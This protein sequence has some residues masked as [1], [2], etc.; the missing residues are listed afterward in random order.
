[1]VPQTGGIM[2]VQGIQ[3]NLARGTEQAE[4]SGLFASCQIADDTRYLRV[5]AEGN[6]LVLEPVRDLVSVLFTSL[7]P[8]VLAPQ[9]AKAWGTFRQYLSET[10]GDLAGR[11][12][13]DKIRGADGNDSEALSVLKV[14]TI[15]TEAEKLKTSV[16]D[17]KSAVKAV[18]WY[19]GLL[20]AKAVEDTGEWE[21]IAENT[22]PS[23]VVKRDGSTAPYEWNKVVKGFVDAGVKT[24]DEP[25]KSAV[26]R[27]QTEINRQP[28]DVTTAKIQAVVLGVMK[29]S[30]IILTEPELLAKC[31][32]SDISS[33]AK[34]D[35][36]FTQIDPALFFRALDHLA[37]VAE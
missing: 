19:Q 6:A 3:L 37:I 33:M 27:I 35:A 21:D 5:L 7:L 30:D 11:I 29:D 8:F 22:P 28:G 26:E 4:G 1:M 15:C 9:N 13:I 17:V 18:I 25:A 36:A 31:E 2:G 34:S 23:S 14:Q 20:A 12:A 10:H 24:S 16:V 32:T